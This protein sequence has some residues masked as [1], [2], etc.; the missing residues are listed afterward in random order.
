MS[1]APLPQEIHCRHCGNRIDR[2]LP[3]CR[4]CGVRNEYAR[5]ES[6]SSSSSSTAIFPEHELT[7]TA[8]VWAGVKGGIYTFLLGTVLTAILFTSSLA[9]NLG[10]IPDIIQE[11]PAVAAATAGSAAFDSIP[12]AVVKFFVWVFFGANFVG[13]TSTGTAGDTTRTVT[14]NVVTDVG[15]VTSLNPVVFH[16]IVVVLLVLFGYLAAKS[17]GYDEVHENAAAGASVAIGYALVGLF[18]ALFASIG[19]GGEFGPT[20]SVGPPLVMAVA[21]FAGIGAVCGAIGGLLRHSRQAD[22]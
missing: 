9:S 20:A 5:P 4:H 3:I 12:V 16:A 11:I 19:F 13:V 2:N 17:T 7:S 8:Q 1:R 21:I 18:G 10:Q 15:S 14:S 22:W 6:T